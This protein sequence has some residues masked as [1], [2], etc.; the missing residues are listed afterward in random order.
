MH[1]DDYSEMFRQLD[2][3]AERTWRSSGSRGRS[4]LPP[5]LSDA[6]D[7]PAAKYNDFLECCV[8]ASWPVFESLDL[9][10]QRAPLTIGLHIE[11]A[12]SKYSIELHYFIQPNLILFNSVL[13]CHIRT[14]L[15]FAVQYLTFH[16][17]PFLCY[18]LL[19]PGQYQALL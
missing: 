18:I 19:L 11:E 2:V 3:A 8:S 17:L 12:L 4:I 13:S 7:I 6:T 14:I 16:N 1:L 5:P 15:H 10:L 9:F